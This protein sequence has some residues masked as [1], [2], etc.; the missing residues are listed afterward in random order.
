MGTRSNARVV[1]RAAL[2][3][4]HLALHIARVRPLPHFSIGVKSILLR[5]AD[6]VIDVCVGHVF[7]L[8]MPRTGVKGVLF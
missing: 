4:G 7:S 3:A 2:V 8:Q 6:A 1:S 5:V